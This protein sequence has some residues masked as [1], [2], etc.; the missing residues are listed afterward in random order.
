MR[1]AERIRRGGRMGPDGFLFE[2]TGG[3]LC[4]DLANTVDN[5]PTS[6]PRELLNDYFDLIS[7]AAQAGAVSSDQAARLR[8]AA[9]RHPGEARR[10]LERARVLREALFS[11]FA[12][13][14]E[15]RPLTEGDLTE[16]SRA[17]KDALSQL[18]LAT[19][20][21]RVEWQWAPG[22]ATALDS[23]LWR[24]ARSGAALLTS[25]DLER[26][27]RCAGKGCAWLFI[28]RSRNRTRRW[29]DMTVCGNR[30]K[31]KRFRQKARR[32]RA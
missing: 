4:L 30:A 5:R 7:W 27:R 1:E 13:A 8:A 22:Q 17:V 11:I 24:A 19:S 2:I 32:T 28:D 14:A 25:P 23:V 29:C 31:A 20:G 26:V 15:K 21:R 6:E 16:L 3:A 10:A 9:Q 12:R 18:R